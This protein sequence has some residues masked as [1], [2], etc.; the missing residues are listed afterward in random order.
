MKRLFYTLILLSALTACGGKEK[1]AEELT[2]AEESQLA[3]S[4]SQHIKDHTLDMKQKTDSVNAEVDSLLE[5]I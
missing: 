3:D 2:P 4:L 1:T 5:G